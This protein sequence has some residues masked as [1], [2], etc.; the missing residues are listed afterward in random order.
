VEWF[1]YVLRSIATGRHYI[2][3][4]SDAKRRLEEHNTRTGRWTSSF[5]PW[6]LIASEEFGSRKDASAREAFFKEPGRH[7]RTTTSV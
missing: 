7:S 6:E 3:M 1:V 5:R 4:T 2:G